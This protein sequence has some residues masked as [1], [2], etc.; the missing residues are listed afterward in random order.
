MRRAK[1]TR[2]SAVCKSSI[3]NLELWR[4]WR[5]GDASQ[6]LAEAGALQCHETFRGR[7][8]G[9]A[10]LIR[11]RDQLVRIGALIAASAD[12]GGDR[13]DGR[14]SVQ[15]HGAGDVAE[16]VGS[17]RPRKSGA[18]GSVVEP[19]RITRDGVRCA[20]FQPVRQGV[21]KLPLRS[22]K[23]PFLESS[24]GVLHGCGRSI[25]ICCGGTSGAAAF[26]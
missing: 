3:A 4:A 15:I 17:G 5:E 2:L 13:V 1:L 18:C 6:D 12:G 19:G 14:G 11:D 25:K 23:N 21:G 7:K 20:E 22:V 16:A 26:I 8:S 10:Q 24:R 9:G